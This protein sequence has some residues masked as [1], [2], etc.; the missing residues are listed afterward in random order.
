MPEPP[1]GGFLTR[2]LFEQ[3]WIAAGLLGFLGALVLWRALS[4]GER[5]GQIVGAVL[6]ALGLIAALIG[7]IVTTPGEH[8]AATVRRFVAAVE[9]AD[10][11]AALALLADNATLSFERPENPPMPRS[12]IELALR[13]VS[14]TQRIESNR[15]THLRG[16]TLDRQTGIVHMA[17]WTETASSMGNVPSQWVIRVTRREA[18]EGERWQV[19]RITCISIAGRAPERRAFGI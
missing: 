5:R 13:V 1:P 18:P 17:C 12:A 8:A 6:V 4:S 10:Q 9:A 15:I 7:S 3:P 2:H 11:A 16:Y 19:A 14:T